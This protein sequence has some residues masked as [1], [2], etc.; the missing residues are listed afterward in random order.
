V[1]N[2]DHF[3]VDG[4]SF[5][6]LHGDLLESLRQPRRYDENQMIYQQG[7]KAEYVYYIKTGRVKIYIASRSGFDKVLTTLTKGSLFGKASFFDG[8]PR[9][10]SA[11]ALQHSEIIAI[12]MPMMTT[13]FQ[14]RP[15]FAIELLEYL[16]KTIQM[17][18]VQID[19][20]AFEQADKRIAGFLCESWNASLPEIDISHEEIGERVGCTRVTVSKMLGR[21]RRNGWIITRYRII[22][23][24]MIDALTEFAYE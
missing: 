18:S 11:K 2:K 5:K 23:I 14:M 19:Q 1:F 22:Q 3:H 21:F 16:S 10:S 15:D 20:M 17:L 9:T 4:S 12:D 13:I 7:D 24:L 8:T 6:I